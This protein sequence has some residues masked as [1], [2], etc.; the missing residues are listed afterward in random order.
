M[1]LWLV[2]ENVFDQQSQWEILKCALRK[3][4]KRYSETIAKEKRKKQ[5]NLEIDL[6]ILEKPLFCDKNIEEYHK[7]KSDLDEIFYNIESQ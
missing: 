5:Q 3:F 6:K 4:S 2:I 7:C 1:T